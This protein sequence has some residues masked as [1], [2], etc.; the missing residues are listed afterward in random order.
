MNW[1]IKLLASICIGK[2]FGQMIIPL[3]GHTIN[4]QKRGV[5][6]N[7]YNLQDVFLLG[8]IEVANKTFNLVFDT[9]SAD[10]F[11]KNEIC[12]LGSS[13]N[14]LND[15]SCKN[16]EGLNTTSSLLSRI[17]IPQPVDLLYHSGSAIADV[18]TTAVK[19]GT[20]T[21]PEMVI[22]VGNKLRKLEYFDG[23]VGL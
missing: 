2:S 7:L 10:F 12:T 23:I 3:H 11:V 18:Y 14:I 8:E 17:T 4:L 21:I 5:N 6:V 20:V 19:F 1:P 15:T 22:G 9:G 16:I 13:S